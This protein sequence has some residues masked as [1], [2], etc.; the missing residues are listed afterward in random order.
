LIPEEEEVEE[1]NDDEEEEEV[2]YGSRTFNRVVKQGVD[3]ITKATKYRSTNLV[4]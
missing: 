1:E 3:N 4:N 2:S